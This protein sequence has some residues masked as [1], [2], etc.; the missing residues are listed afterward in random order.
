MYR[1]TFSSKA[2]KAFL[3]LPKEQAKRIKEAIEAL[4]EEPRSPGTI[5]LENAPVAR[6]RRRVGNWRILF[7]INDEDKVIE[8]LD[9]RKRDERTYK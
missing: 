3:D 9:V 7:D 2:R 6:Y 4:V 5:K 8:I 1:A